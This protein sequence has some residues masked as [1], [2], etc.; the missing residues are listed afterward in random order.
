[1]VTNVLSAARV[2]GAAHQ[3]RNDATAKK[4]G[5][6]CLVKRSKPNVDG[7]VPGD[8]VQRKMTRERSLTLHMGAKGW[9]V[10]KAPSKSKL[11]ARPPPAIRV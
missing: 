4:G 3:L 6:L 1:V 11:R 2:R 9:E 5:E 7:G 10:N 8:R